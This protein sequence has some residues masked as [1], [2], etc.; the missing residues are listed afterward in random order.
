MWA[1]QGSDLTGKRSELQRVT[2]RQSSRNPFLL[3]TLAGNIQRIANGKNHDNHHD[4]S[5]AVAAG[6]GEAERTER[7]ERQALHAMRHLYRYVPDGAGDGPQPTPG[8]APGTV[9]PA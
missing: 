1:F 4:S 7:R 2:G 3:Q 8:H 9:W 6:A 5:D